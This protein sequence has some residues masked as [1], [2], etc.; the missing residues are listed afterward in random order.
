MKTKMMVIFLLLSASALYAALLGPGTYRGIYDVD[1]WGRRV[2]SGYLVSE[3]AAR[4][5]EPYRGKSVAAQVSEIDQQD[6][7]GSVTIRKVDSVA[8]LT[9]T[10]ALDLSIQMLIARVSA[11]NQTQMTLVFTNTSGKAVYLWPGWDETDLFLAGGSTN[12]PPFMDN[13]FKSFRFRPDVLISNGLQVV[14]ARESPGGPDRVVVLPGGSCRLPIAFALT[15][16]G[17]YQAWWRIYHTVGPESGI[18]T[19]SSR[20]NFDVTPE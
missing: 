10:P 13:L 15:V 7:R 19:Q 1:R 3:D 17:E 2:F 12:Q 20:V 5:L 6:W 18:G 11:S 9:N 16:P 4:A 14:D 8:V